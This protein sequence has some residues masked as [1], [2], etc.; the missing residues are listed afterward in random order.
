MIMVG[1]VLMLLLFTHYFFGTLGLEVEAL[2]VVS[3]AM[4]MDVTVGT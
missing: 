3:G 2:V 4:T 1:G